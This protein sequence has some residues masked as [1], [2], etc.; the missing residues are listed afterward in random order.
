[1][2]ITLRAARVNKNLKQRDAAKA[3]GITD[4]TLCSWENAKSF[5]NAKQ[6]GDI[7]KL[8][9]VT[10]NDIIFLPSDVDKSDI[11]EGE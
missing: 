11:Q 3:L 1:M 8:Y 2:G 5:P 9:G 7:E 6:I 10:Y 4:R